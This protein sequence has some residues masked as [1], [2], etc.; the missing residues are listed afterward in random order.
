MPHVQIAELY[1]STNKK[2]RERK[3]QVV[4]QVIISLAGLSLG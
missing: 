3:G 1:G 2:R 4:A